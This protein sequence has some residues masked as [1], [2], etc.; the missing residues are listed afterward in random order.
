[1][2]E[3][4]SRGF[5]SKVSLTSSYH[6]GND[7]PPGLITVNGVP[8]CARVSWTVGGKEILI[9]V[10]AWRAWKGAAAGDVWQIQREGLVAS[11][12]LPS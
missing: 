6:Y 8:M 4:C 12:S 1:M 2:S 9:M 3:A 5:S 7:A 11:N 10:R